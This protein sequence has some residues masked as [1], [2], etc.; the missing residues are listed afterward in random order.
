MNYM[1]GTK[2]IMKEVKTFLGMQLL[3]GKM[4]KTLKKL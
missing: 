4:R 2:S 1:D 3:D